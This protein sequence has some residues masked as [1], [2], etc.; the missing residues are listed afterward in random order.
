MTY[1]N[2]FE[3]SKCLEHEMLKNVG[4]TYAD[5]GSELSRL[6]GGVHGTATCTGAAG[7][8]WSCSFRAKF[9]DLLQVSRPS[10]H[11]KVGVSGFMQ[12]IIQ[13]E[14]NAWRHRIMA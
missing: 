9:R 4:V 5:K 11:G 3:S 1:Y 14:F 10:Q 13:G 2:R 7:G 8:G 12:T 6:Q